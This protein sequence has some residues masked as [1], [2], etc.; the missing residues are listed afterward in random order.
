MSVQSCVFGDVICIIVACIVEAKTITND[1]KRKMIAKAPGNLRFWG[2]L[3]C[4]NYHFCWRNFN[5]AK[6]NRGCVNLQ[7]NNTI[8]L[9]IFLLYHNYIF[10]FIF[11]FVGIMKSPDRHQRNLKPT[12]PLEFLMSQEAYAKGMKADKSNV[13]FAYCD[14]QSH[15]ASHTFWKLKSLIWLFVFVEKI[16]VRFLYKISI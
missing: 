2:K 8:I 15:Y 1:V 16:E 14:S 5:D 3:V 10:D 11:R 12:K 4:Q 9:S 13:R 6:K 7:Y